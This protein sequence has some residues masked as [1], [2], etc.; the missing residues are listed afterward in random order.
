[1][2]KQMTGSFGGYAEI[3]GLEAQVK[4]N[5]KVSLSDIAKFIPNRPYSYKQVL[6]F[7]IDNG[8]LPA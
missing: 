2:S 5:N 7:V 1:M 6:Q 8:R 4:S 3:L